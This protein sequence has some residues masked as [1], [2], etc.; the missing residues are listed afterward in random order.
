MLR[1]RLVRKILLG[2]VCVGLAAASLFIPIGGGAVSTAATMTTRAN[3]ATNPAPDLPTF[4]SER[5]KAGLSLLFIHHSVGG[6]LLADAGDRQ[7]MGDEIW[8]AHPN[9]GG[10]RR[11][12]EAQGYQVHEA[13]YGSQL[14]SHTDRA[15][16][17]AKFRDQ[18]PAVTACAL[19]DQRL[20]DGQ[21]NQIVV[22]KSC[23]PENLLADDGA[24]QRARD[25]LTALLPLFAQHP[26]TLFVYLTTPPLAPNT[27]AEPVWKSLARF[28]MRKPQP[29]PRLAKSGP[30]ARRLNDWITSPG[31][32]LKDYRLKNLV[33][34]DLY[35]VLTDH[36]RTDYLAFTT[37][38]GTDS[39]PSREGNER[40]AAEFVPFLNRAVRRA[41]LAE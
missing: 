26:D 28:V 6:R 27:P 30:A 38:G 11:S 37:D 40:V 1:S 8:K 19:N 3:P 35:D 23:F 36:G 32:W 9:G 21:R 29:G 12:L 7:A 18:M 20:P 24:E 22:F 2:G 14:G 31:G 34:F 4:S 39:H 13:S 15:D 41:G 16:W 5:P 33:V 10:L 17:L 25:N